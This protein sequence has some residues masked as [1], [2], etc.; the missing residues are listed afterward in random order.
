MKQF[1]NAADIAR[2]EKVDKSTVTDWIK[3][4]Y[5]GKVRKIHPGGQYVIPLSVYEKFKKRRANES[6]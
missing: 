5:F 3:K 1:L 2:V 4:G 6:S